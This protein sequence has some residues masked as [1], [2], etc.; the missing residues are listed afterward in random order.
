MIWIVTLCLLATFAWF[1]FN[2]LNEKRWV[3]AHSHDEAVASDEGFLP[4]FTQMKSKVGPDAE[5]KV[6]IS[7]ENSRFA[8][9]VA[10]VQEK[11]SK[12]GDYL[13]QKAAAA[14]GDG[15]ALQCRRDVRAL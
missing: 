5:G 13:E 14:R 6:S 12:A 7:E 9:A 3:E 4:S 11:T 15:V 2:A 10:K 1:L 8:R